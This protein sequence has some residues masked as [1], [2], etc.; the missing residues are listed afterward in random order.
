MPKRT[1]NT[2]R[3]EKNNSENRGRQSN[4]GIPPCLQFLNLCKP[5]LLFPFPPS[6]LIHQKLP[7]SP[8]IQAKLKGKEEVLDYF[9]DYLSTEEDP[10]LLIYAVWCTEGV[11]NQQLQ[12][13]YVR[14]M[15]KYRT[16]QNIQTKITKL[17]H[18]V[19]CELPLRPACSQTGAAP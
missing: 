19:A 7:S 16:H 18:Q 4:D 8:V 14:L 3:R 12:E 11:E 1:R 9:L 15:D 10:T 5:T 6:S 17:P 2:L 13:L